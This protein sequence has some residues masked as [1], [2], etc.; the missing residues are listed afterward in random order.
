MKRI[1][2]VLMISGLLSCQEEITK[3]TPHNNAGSNGGGTTLPSNPVEGKYAN[4]LSI[5]N[6]STLDVVT[7]NLEHFPKEDAATLTLLKEMI[8]KMDADIIA[9]Q[10]IE[11]IPHF[12][13]LI[14]SLPG[15]AGV[16]APS[17]SQRPGYIYKTSEITSFAP[18]TELFTDDP[19]AFPRPALKTTITHVSGEVVTLINV[20]LKCC[21]D[22]GPT[23]GYSIDR[24][25][26]AATKLKSYIDSTL[27][28]ASVIVLGDYN[29]DLTEPEGNGVFTNIINDASNYEFADMDIAEGSTSN[30]SYQSTDYISHLDHILITNELFD[31]LDEV[32]T[33]KFS[34][35]DGGYI[36]NVTDHYP[37]I[38][39]LKDLN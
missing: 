12:N 6:N 25:K 10:E 1:L 4:C 7:W 36:D 38:M 18:V 16:T 34:N 32:R 20:H 8:S 9:V 22:Y 13:E 24:R 15:Y 37:V 30:F 21:D 35:C 28:N 26:A 19:G 29:E 5:L 23:Y 17:G 27:P 2:S 14:A 11:S 3:I 31:N 33:I 39:R